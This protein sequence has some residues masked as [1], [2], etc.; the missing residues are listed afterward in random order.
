MFLI[1]VIPLI[2]ATA[3]GTLSYYSAS[4]YPVGTF[5]T[6]TIRG[7]EKKAMV[8]SVNLV[9]DAK[10]SLRQ[11]GFTLKKLPPQPEVFSVPENIRLTAD[12]L[13]KVYPSSLGAILFHL[14]PP[15]VHHGKYQYPSI[16][17]LKHNEETAPTVLTGRLSER[18]IAYRTHIR[19]VLARRG[20]VV[21][22]VPTSI[23]AEQARDE[24][25]QGIEDR[26][27]LFSP[28][29]NEKERRE[30]YMKFED[31]SLAKLIITTT[32]HAYLDRVDLLSII[33]ESEGSELYRGRHRPYLDHRTTLITHAKVCGRS[34]ILGDIL[35][36][37]E[38]EFY[39]REDRYSTIS[40]ETKRHAFTSPLTIHFQKDKP[41]IEAP[42]SL[43][44][45]TLRER[46]EQTLSGKGR[47][48]LYGA[49]R[50]IAPV[51]A[52]YDCGYIF[53]CPDSGTP[54]SLIK[55]TSKTG[56]EE[57]W[58]VSSTSGKRIRASDVCPNCG[59]W[60][61]RE[62]GIGIQTV[63][64]E[65]LE[66]FPNR[67][68]YIFDHQTASTKNKARK[69]LTEF[70]AE[71]NAILVGTQIALPFLYQPGVE[72]SA[73]VSL[74]ATRAIPT[75]RSDETFLR[76]LLQL[77]DFSSK[78]VLVQTRTEPDE[79]LEYAKTGIIDSYYNDEIALRQTLLYPPFCTFIL[80]S[81]QGKQAEI[82]AVETD[83]KH[84]LEAYGITIY[85]NPLSTTTKIL[86]HALLRVKNNDPSLATIINT[87]RTFPPYIKVEIDPSRIV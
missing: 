87:V 36:R 68:V 27:V 53:R 3:I 61:L 80:L 83:L 51:V 57:R 34:I 37:P 17:S 45:T 1:E 71:K 24:L 86:R 7:Q 46:V 81:W 74:D 44:S 55:T 19:S 28:S 10:T 49:R 4:S 66:K 6:V 79:L 30:A 15:E 82:E 65:C 69:I 25:S 11:A 85:S 47:V 21:M 40:V 56:N 78:E 32:S 5:L 63:Y 75:W 2:K 29:Q 39:R 12:A 50:G 23:E 9:N 26:V 59:S 42:F 72:L 73:V 84:K 48:F 14:L 8:I 58:F 43:F 70:Y 67:S 31:T 41:T 18:Y 64:E 13:T 35:P 22:V 33:V 77:R 76:L 60:R 16:S 38:T 62:R 20:S 52:C 54:Y